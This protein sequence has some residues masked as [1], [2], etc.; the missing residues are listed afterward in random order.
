M[1][2]LCTICEGSGLRLVERPD[3]S[4]AARDCDCRVQKR[5][6]RAL[7]SAKIPR[8]YE[9]STFQNYETADRDD[10]LYTLNAAKY[11]S[12]KFALAYPVDTGGIGL[13]F[14]GSVGTGK[15]HLAV[16]VLKAILEKGGTGIFYHFQ[17]L[18]KQIQ[19]SFNR[20]VQ[21][22]ESEI[23]EPILNAEVLVLDELGASKPSDWVFDTIAHVLNTRYNER[24]TTI[25]TTNYPNRD[26]L[27]VPGKVLS[28][29]EEAREALRNETLGD[30]IG[31]RMRSRIQEM[32]MVVEM[33]GPDYRKTEKRAHFG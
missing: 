21:A 5:K 26:A 22:T 15:T 33:I 9:R 1:D 6:A 19:N 11:T 29:F 27:L 17:D 24:R 28:V 30:R 18:I 32:C 16:S 25:I 2:D 13:L 3:G 12:E 7:A 8:L 20:N 23:L 31:E 10:K 4:R 14:T